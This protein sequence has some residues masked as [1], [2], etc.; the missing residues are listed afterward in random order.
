MAKQRLP[1]QLVYIYKISFV[2][3]GFIIVIKQFQV[4]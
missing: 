4:T 3:E 1:G 2:M